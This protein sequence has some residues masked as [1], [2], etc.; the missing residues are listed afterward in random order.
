[1]FHVE[2]GISSTASEAQKGEQTDQHHWIVIIFL[3]SVLCSVHA[4]D[5]NHKRGNFSSS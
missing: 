2:A 4:G 5:L 3:F 1:M